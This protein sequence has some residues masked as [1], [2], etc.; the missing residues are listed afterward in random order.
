M[1]FGMKYL[2]EIIFSLTVVSVIGAGLY[3]FTRENDW[4]WD[5]IPGEVLKYLSDLATT[6]LGIIPTLLSKIGGKK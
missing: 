6:I 4:K 3:K 2:P 1:N 5:D